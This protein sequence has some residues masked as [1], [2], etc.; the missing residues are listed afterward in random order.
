MIPSYEDRQKEKQEIDAWA[1]ANIPEY[2]MQGEPTKLSIRAMIRQAKAYGID[3]VYN[4]VH[5]AKLYIR[6][7]INIGFSQSVPWNKKTTS[8]D[9]NNNFNSYTYE[10]TL[11]LNPYMQKH[12]KSMLLHEFSRAKEQDLGIIKFMIFE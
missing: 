11:M 1:R 2:R 6:T 9:T 3:N 5:L 8:N 7:N 4:L 12:I 10:S